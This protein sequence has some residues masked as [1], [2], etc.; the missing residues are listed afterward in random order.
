MH[1]FKSAAEFQHHMRKYHL[2]TPYQCSASGCERRNGKGFF[3]KIDLEKHQRKA[4]EDEYQ[5][6]LRSR[7]EWLD[8]VPVYFQRYVK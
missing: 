8:A 2:E 7:E 5:E 4:H 3:R 1:A 6:L